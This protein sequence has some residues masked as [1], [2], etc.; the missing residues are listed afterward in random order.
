MCAERLEVDAAPVAG[1]GGDLGATGGGELDGEAPDP[2]A[3][4]GDQHARAEQPAAAA[5]GAQRGQPGDAEA[6]RAFGGDGV[7]QRREALDRHGDALRPATEV[8][9][10]DDTRAG[11]RAAAVQGGDENPA[12]DVLARPPPFRSS[13]EQT[14]LAAVDRER[15]DLHED[16][17]RRGLGV[18]HAPQ[19]GPGGGAD[20]GE[21]GGRRG[22]CVGH[23]L[24]V[25][26]AAAEEKDRSATASEPPVMGA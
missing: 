11:V 4:P 16:L 3:G 10:R 7:G 13:G 1:E 24:T 18:G 23:G 25:E 12:G 2:T 9:H 26:S 19:L 20:I 5:Q 22:E 14:Q 21:H 15:F 6:G 8:D 17:V